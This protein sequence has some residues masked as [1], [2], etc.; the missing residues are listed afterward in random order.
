MKYQIT[1]T[2]NITLKNLKAIQANNYLSANCKQDYS[3]SDVDAQI[4]IASEN[5]HAK[6]MKSSEAA[7]MEFNSFYS[8]PKAPKK[9]EAFRFDF[10]FLTVEEANL[11]PN[12]KLNLK[13]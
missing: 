4:W 1:N 3:Q 6:W 9:Q 13:H 2:K 7:E 11:T 12:V 5:N 10:G 8:A